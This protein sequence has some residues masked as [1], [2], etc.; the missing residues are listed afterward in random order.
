LNSAAP[1]RSMPPNPSATDKPDP[2][3]PGRPTPAGAPLNKNF[4]TGVSVSK[5]VAILLCTYQGQAYLAEQLDSYA[6]QTHEAWDL[7]VS[8][9]GSKDR[10]HA[11]L[12]AYRDTWR[13]RHEVT[14]FQG[15][16]KGFAAN[17]LSLL[18][19][20]EVEADYFSYSDQDDIWQAEKIERAVQWLDTVDPAIP[21]LYCCRTQLVDE[22]NQDIGCSPLFQRPPGFRN[23]LVQ[24]IAGGNTMVFNQAAR[25]LML[26]I[27]PAADVVAHDW[28]TYQAVCAGGG[29]VHY[30]PRPSLR[31]RQHGGNLIGSNS[32][33]SARLTRVRMLLQ[34]QLK[35][36]NERNIRALAAIRSRMPEEARSVFDR[37]RQAREQSLPARV[38]GTL[39]SGVYRQTVPGNI[40]LLV[41]AIFNKI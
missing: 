40:G 3:E 39:H 19:R 34:G 15:P 31:Y 41:A 7:W 5:K 28:L 20:P 12:D 24:N 13:G 10:T 26:A 9:D 35:D 8:D 6:A 36:W 18:C 2:R 25:R 4:R 22:S 27:G 17:F 1:Q 16:R 32:G 30:D 23:A 14:V 37:F 38:W 11:I 29:V 21:A 33:L